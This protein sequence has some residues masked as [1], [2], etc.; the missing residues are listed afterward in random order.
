MAFYLCSQAYQKL[1]FK[2]VD[3]NLQF[4]AGFFA[5]GIRYTVQIVRMNY[6]MN[7]RIWFDL[8]LIAIS[9]VL[10]YSIIFIRIE[11]LKNTEVSQIRDSRVMAHYLKLLE[12]DIEDSFIRS[13]KIILHGRNCIKLNCFCQSKDTSSKPE[14]FLRQIYEN[15]INYFCDVADPLL[16]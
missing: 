9:L 3:D 2:T 4:F 13:T 14:Y 5:V 10:G 12:R 16:W 15:S 1:V 11:K 6:E 8:P 7:S